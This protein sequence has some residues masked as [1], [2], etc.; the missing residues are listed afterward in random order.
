MTTTAGDGIAGDVQ[1]A[2]ATGNGAAEGEREQRSMLGAQPQT[3]TAA[4]R[5]DPLDSRPISPVLSPFPIADGSRMTARRASCPGIT[6]SSN[7]RRRPRVVDDAG[8]A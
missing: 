5:D 8:S 4:V 3:H 7:G 6:S 1:V 2:L